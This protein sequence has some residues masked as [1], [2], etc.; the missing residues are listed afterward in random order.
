MSSVIVRAAIAPMFAQPGLRFEQVS[1]LVLG[2]TGA[3]AGRGG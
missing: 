2:E 3:R 1:Q